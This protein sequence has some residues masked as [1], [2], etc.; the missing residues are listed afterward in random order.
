MIPDVVTIQAGLSL[1]KARPQ[2][3]LDAEL[4]ELRQFVPAPVHRVQPMSFEYGYLLGLE[5]ARVILAGDSRLINAGIK[6]EE[7][8]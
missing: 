2:A 5:V 1:L 3:V 7:L 4:L 8:L 6:P